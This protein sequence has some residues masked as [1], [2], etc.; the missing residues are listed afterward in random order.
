MF[1]GKTISPHPV[2]CNFSQ[3]KSGNIDYIPFQKALVLES[4]KEDKELKE[5]LEQLQRAV[6]DTFSALS[7]RFDALEARSNFH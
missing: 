5:E 1:C 7:H 6:C 2:I 3:I 4:S